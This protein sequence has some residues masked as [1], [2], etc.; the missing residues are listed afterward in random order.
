MLGRLTSAALMNRIR[1]FHRTDAEARSTV[2]HGGTVSDGGGGTMHHASAD[3]QLLHLAV[4][5]ALQ[6]GMGEAAH[7]LLALALPLT[8]AARPEW[9]PAAPEKTVALYFG[10]LRTSVHVMEH[11]YPLLLGMIAA[12]VRITHRTADALCI[13]LRGSK[14]DAS[15]VALT[16]RQR[17]AFFI[18][19]PLAD[20]KAPLAAEAEARRVSATGDQWQSLAGHKGRMPS[21]RE[22]LRILDE[23][24]LLAE[25]SPVDLAS[26]LGPAVPMRPETL[27]TA[28]AASSA[29][30]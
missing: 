28:A 4:A 27:T 3:P 7:D 2:S 1:S 5:A 19:P 14:G 30:P 23:M 18:R 24:Q 21:E 6:R 11:A 8:A 13:A 25:A 15:T 26:I 10:S 22:L 29:R 17:A 16:R 12:R 9:L 20:T